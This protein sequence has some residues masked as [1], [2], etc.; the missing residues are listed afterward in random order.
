MGKL[1][2]VIGEGDLPN[3]LT[4]GL[5]EKGYTTE[6]I[7][8]VDEA[9]SRED[10]GPIVGTTL[11]LGGQ[12]VPLKQIVQGSDHRVFVWTGDS[13]MEMIKSKSEP[14]HTYYTL[15]ELLALL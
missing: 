6:R 14:V 3:D 8:S 7:S 1:V 11:S 15:Q 10:Y 4:S 9:T 12:W 13:I 2:L 5:S